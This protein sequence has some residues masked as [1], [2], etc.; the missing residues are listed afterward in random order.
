MR[1]VMV[2]EGQ[3]FLTIAQ[4]TSQVDYLRLAYVQAMN[5][6]LLHPGAQYAVIVDHNT[7][8]KVNNK[9][10]QAFDHIIEL[11]EDLNA[12]GSEWKLANES[13]VLDLSPFKETIKLESDLLFTRSIQHW[14]TAFRLRNIVL[15]TGCK[16]YKQE[17][18][19]SRAYRQFFDINEL[20]DV[21]NGIMYFRYTAEAVEFFRTARLILKNW[22]YLKNNVLKQ[23][24]ENTPSTDVLYA[25]TAKVVG[26]EICTIPT[27]DFIN[28]V[29]MKPAIQ[30]WGNTDR[31]WTDMVM[32][33]RNNDMIRIHNINQYHPVH[34]HDKTYITEEIVNGYEQRYGIR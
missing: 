5:V 33:E 12:Q 25:I 15:S 24:R 4:N 18:A 1:Y 6:K 7:L 27:M 23:C 20:P 21:Y 11:Q 13:Q 2:K 10:W 16:N 29:H 8:A 34:Y 28:F 17:P 31:L 30:G 32:H 3:G 14:W 22:D 19:T 26:E 9:H